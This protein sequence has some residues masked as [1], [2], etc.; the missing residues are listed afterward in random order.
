MESLLEK[1]RKLCFWCVDFFKGGTI[2]K[3]YKEI[4][5]ILEN[6]HTEESK[7]RRNDHIVNL[8]EHARKTTPFYAENAKG[9]ELSDFPVIN[10]GTVRNNFDQF[11]S[12][13]FVDAENTPVVTS[14]STGTPFKLFHNK[15]KRCRNN[16]DIIYFAKRGGFEIGSR[17]LYMKV[18]N[19]INK[20]SPLKLWMENIRPYSIFNY[21]DSDVQKLIEDLENDRSKKGMVCF[22]STC[23][24]IV[25][26]LDSVKAQPSNYNITSIITNSDALS[27]HT[28][29]R[30][31]HYFKIPVV[32]RYSNMECGMLAQQSCLGGYEFHV[33]WASF[34]V[35]LLHPDKDIPAAPG[36]MG[37]VVITDLFNYCMPLIRYDTGDLAYMSENSKENGAP[38]LKS[39]EGRKVD[40]IKDTKDKVITSHIVTVNMWKYAELKQYQF[41]QRGAKEYVFRLNPWDTFPRE[42]E[43]IKEFKGYLGQDANIEI[44][45]VEGIPLLS[46]GK[47][48][49]VVNEINN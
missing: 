31:E 19:D 15:N 41:A 47:R 42:E 16:A 4:K 14:G 10:K 24:V 30:M 28:K 29:D 20:K 38:V 32:S 25:N 11:R 46:S 45:Y 2:R 22:A 39:I 13:L 49:L 7:T 34:H 35:E 43:L 18:W 9:T 8:L 12:S 26:Y 40:L 48:K 37:R 44:E 17:L 6:F 3:H 36:E 1:F 33:N 23:D 27:N 5:F 21:S